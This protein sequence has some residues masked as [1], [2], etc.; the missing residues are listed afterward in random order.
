MSFLF[1]DA[2]AAAGEMVGLA[3]GQRSE[4]SLSLLMIVGIFALF[5]FMMIRP[6]NKRAKQHK[7]LMAKIQK[8]D[9]VV[10]S[11]GILGKVEKLINETHIKVTLTTDVEIIVLRDAV[12]SVLP[13][14]TLGSL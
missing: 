14:G 6:Q 1:S 11:S 12:V 8:G 13:K 2:Y 7:E 9:E 4:S 3:G 5:Y 10:L